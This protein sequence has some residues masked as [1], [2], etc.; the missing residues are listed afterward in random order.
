[1]VENFIF[2]L[3]GVAAQSLGY[4]H[5]LA[6]IT[7]FGPGAS[8]REHVDAYDLLVVPIAGLLVLRLGQ[9]REEPVAPG[10]FAVARRRD[11]RLS[12]RKR[13]RRHHDRGGRPSSA[14]GGH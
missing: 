8:Y 3:R 9:G 5:V 6:K 13:R 7:S 10:E 12:G 1:L 2:N 11:T 4:D 14:A